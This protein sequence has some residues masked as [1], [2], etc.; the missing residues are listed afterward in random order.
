MLTRTVLLVCATAMGRDLWQNIE[1]T[2][3]TSMLQPTAF[4][5]ERAA[6]AKKRADLLSAREKMVSSSSVPSNIVINAMDTKI[7]AVD[8]ALTHERE[9]DELQAIK[10]KLSTGSAK[11]F[12]VGD[13]LTVI[14][15]QVVA[16]EIKHQKAHESLALKLEELDV[17]PGDNAVKNYVLDA[18]TNEIGEDAI[19]MVGDV[20]NI[21]AAPSPDVGTK[22]LA[23]V[24]LSKF[25][26]DES[27]VKHN[28]T[29]EALNDLKSKLHTGVYSQLPAGDPLTSI[30]EEAV[31]EEINHQLV[32]ESLVEE[33]EEVPFSQ[34]YNHENLARNVLLAAITNEKLVVDEVSETDMETQ[35]GQGIIVK[36]GFQVQS[37][38]NSVV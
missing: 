10:S 30:A 18:I 38:S 28:H 26:T 17:K 8:T 13:P 29:I 14:A 21:D 12:P 36:D 9:I 33:I 1:V 25:H 5:A 31:S 37:E 11:L 16:E 3:T 6:L 22:D 15:G 23:G 27:L 32:H 34:N 2:E 19:R 35:V 20:M 24:L 4:S 7:H